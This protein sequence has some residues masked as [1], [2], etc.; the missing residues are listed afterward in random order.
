MTRT[1]TNIFFLLLL[2]LTGATKSNAQEKQRLFIDSLDNAFDVSHYLYDLHGFLPVISPITEPAVGY[3]AA[4]AGLFFIPKEKKETKRFQMPDVVGVVGGLTENNTWF[5]GAGYMGFW[6]DDRIRYRGIFG[7]GDIKLKY[8]GTNNQNDRYIDFSI[9]SYFLLQQAVF[10]IK[11]SNFLLG[12]VY[13][14]SN[15]TVTLF[16]DSELINPRDKVLNNSGIG[17][18]SEYEALNNVFSPTQGIRVNL[19]YSQYNEIIGSDTNFGR[20]SS[21]MYYYKPLF[22]DKL[23]SGIRLESQLALGDVP[24]Y[25]LPFVNLRGVPAMR[26]Q[27]ELTALVETEQQFMINNRW[28]VV[29]FAGYGRTAKS[30][31]EIDIGTNS[32]NAGTGF[33]YLIARAFGL[34]MGADVARG[35]EQWAFYIVVGTSWLR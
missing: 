30:L 1:T 24:F 26:Y 10:R 7:Y 13:Q 35:P 11:D 25:M 18:I 34:R 29:G 4:F 9:A 14:F 22:N 23:I 21:F 3:G 27:G 15:S 28:S 31:D 20:I 12:G 16:E 6:N 19:T 2:F 33:R 8:Y 17:I 5:G 32:W